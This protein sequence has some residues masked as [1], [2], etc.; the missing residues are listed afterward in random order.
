[1]ITYFFSRI[2][3]ASCMDNWGLWT[4]GK[5]SYCFLRFEEVEEE[6]SVEE[7]GVVDDVITRGFVWTIGKRKRK[8]SFSWR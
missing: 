1:M 7:A 4:F 8:N 5:F 6:E 2:A 3:S